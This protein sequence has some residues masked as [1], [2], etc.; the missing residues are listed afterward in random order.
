MSYLN[1]RKVIVIKQQ[2]FNATNFNFQSFPFIVELF[3]S[4][5][6][7]IDDVFVI[8]LGA[9]VEDPLIWSMWRFA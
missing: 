1:N 9:I 5:L 7:F 3:Y 2:L 8:V 4:W 6:R